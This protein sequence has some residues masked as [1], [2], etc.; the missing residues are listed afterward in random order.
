MRWE[1]KL[2]R[3][4]V[5]GDKRIVERFLFL[6]V[7]LEGQVRW[8]EWARIEQERYIGWVCVPDGPMYKALKWRYAGWADS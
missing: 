7:S 4:W 8:L 1:K 3:E 5:E 2:R 6:P